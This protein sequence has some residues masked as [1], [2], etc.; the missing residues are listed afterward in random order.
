MP[1]LSWMHNM[2]VRKFS[3][4]GGWM[5]EFLPDGVRQAQ[6][7]G[8]Y[9]LNAELETKEFN[10]WAKKEKKIS[11]YF[12]TNSIISDSNLFFF[13]SPFSFSQSD[14]FWFYFC[15]LQW[16]RVLIRRNTT[17]HVT[18]SGCVRGP[19]PFAS[20][21]LRSNNKVGPLGG[22]SALVWG[23]GGWGAG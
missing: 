6:F 19:Q 5:G 21:S 2:L 14:G 10:V 9:T 17:P 22:Q 4:S 1:L 11:I 23:E 13:P 15:S 3:Q 20:S 18:L 8:G 7:W 16:L 12:K